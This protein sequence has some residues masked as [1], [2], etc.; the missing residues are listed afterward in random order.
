VRRNLPSPLGRRLAL[1]VALAVAPPAVLAACGGDPAPA[2]AAASEDC[3][4]TVSARLDSGQ[5]PGRHDIY[6]ADLSDSGGATLDS[7]RPQIE[8]IVT[9]AVEGRATL[10]VNVVGDSASDTTTIL[11]CPALAPLVNDEDARAQ[12]TNNLLTAV[13]D[14]VLDAYPE[15][16]QRAGSDLYGAL[17]AESSRLPDDGAPVRIVSTSDGMQVGVTDIPLELPGVTV[18]LYGIGRLAEQGLDSAAAALLR[19]TWS[20]LLTQAGAT[21]VIRFTAY[22]PGQVGR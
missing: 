11:D 18:E 1:G 10:T 13:T 20:Q 22:V 16:D 5:D 3:P 2:A 7:L 15:R 17:L 4:R 14:A 8:G 12:V 19:D 6:L 21:P 9:D